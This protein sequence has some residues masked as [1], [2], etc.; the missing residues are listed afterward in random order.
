MAFERADHHGL[1]LDHHLL[2]L[3]LDAE[4][5]VLVALFALAVDVVDEALLHRTQLLVH[6]RLVRSDLSLHLVIDVLDARL[7]FALQLTV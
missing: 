5:H 2:L 4:G 6:L 7:R 1:V 3:G